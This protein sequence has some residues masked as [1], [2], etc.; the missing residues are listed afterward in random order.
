MHNTFVSWKVMTNEVSM[1]HV[2]NLIHSVFGLLPQCIFWVGK[3]IFP[4]LLEVIHNFVAAPTRK[5]R[6][7]SMCAKVFCF[8]NCSLEDA[9]KKSKREVSC[10]QSYKK[11]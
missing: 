7:L 9:N 4:C 10:T 2:S 8:N 5:G 11:S 3:P 6:C 1:A